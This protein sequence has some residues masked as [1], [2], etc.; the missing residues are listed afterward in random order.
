[1]LAKAIEEAGPK[2]AAIREWLSELES[3]TAVAGVTGP[4]HFG[5][6]GDRLGRDVV[7]TR[8]RGGVLM[9]EAGA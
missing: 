3:G 2:R 1:M 8:V 5:R 6:G 7:V 9:V 4:L